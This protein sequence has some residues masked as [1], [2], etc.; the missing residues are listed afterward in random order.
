L[1]CFFQSA[2]SSQYTPDLDDDTPSNGPSTSATAVTS[3]DSQSDQLLNFLLANTKC[4]ISKVPWIKLEDIPL[5]MIKE[6]AD[7]IFHEYP[8][9]EQVLGMPQ[10]MKEDIVKLLSVGT[11]VTRGLSSEK[12]ELVN[13]KK[14]KVFFG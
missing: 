6:I 7:V 13:P 8:E 2:C 10:V 5:T 14:V 1:C 3:P 12:E 11:S 4:I 9:A